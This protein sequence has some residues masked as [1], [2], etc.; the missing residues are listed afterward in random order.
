MLKITRFLERADR[1]H[2]AWAHFIS[3]RTGHVIPLFQIYDDGADLVETSFMMQGLLAARGYYTRDTP[4]EREL[5]ARIT[6]LWQGVDWDWFRATRKARRALLALVARL[7]L[8]HPLPA[9]R[10]ERGDDHLSPRRRLADPPRAAVDLFHRLHRARGLTARRG[11]ISASPQRRAMS[12]RPTT[13]PGSTGP[14]FFTHYS[15]MGYDPR[16][17]RDRF[18]NYFQSQPG[19]GPDQP[20]LFDRQ[21]ETSSRAMARTAGA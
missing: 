6:R 21:S 5:R 14:L 2:G 18:S 19:A 11:P 13:S 10:L 15:Y 20:G 7:R 3:G 4:A 12:R 1:F 17:V 8:V 9:R 16:G